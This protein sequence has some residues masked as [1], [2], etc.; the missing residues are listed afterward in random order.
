MSKVKFSQEKHFSKQTSPFQLILRWNTFVILLL[1]S[2]F[3]V[4]PQKGQ[5]YGPYGAYAYPQAAF[6]Q[7]AYPQAGYPMAS[8]GSQQGLHYSQY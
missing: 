4:Y 8:Y 2:N 6:P 7:A 1:F 3:S 5:P